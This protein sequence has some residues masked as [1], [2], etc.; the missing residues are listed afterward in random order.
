MAQKVQVGKKFLDKENKIWQVTKYA[1]NWQQENQHRITL[2]RISA[3]P[4]GVKRY[5]LE[6]DFPPADLSEAPDDAK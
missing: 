4:L 1:M 6:R 3:G 2:T 5:I